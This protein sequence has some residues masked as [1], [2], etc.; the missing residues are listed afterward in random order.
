MGNDGGSISKVQNLKLSLDPEVKR[1]KI[2]TNE[3]NSV[4]RWKV[5]R[6]TNTP[7]RL[8]IVSDY[9]GYLY[10]KESILEWMLASPSKGCYSTSQIK[11]LSHIKRIHDV[12]ELANL[13]EV[14]T[15]SG[16]FLRCNFGDD[17][18]GDDMKS[19][20]VYVVPCGDV[21]PRITTELSSSND[22]SMKCPQCM[23][24]CSKENIIP[25]NPQ[26]T[27]D[28]QRLKDRYQ[29]LSRDNLYHD[30]TAKKRKKM[31]RRRGA[32]EATLSSKKTKI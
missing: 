30:G 32:N 19:T 13:D 6:V 14:K 11:Q 29:R 27:Q 7:L 24:P 21:L 3:F 4:S 9:K 2:E 12:V 28:I 8:P 26:A 1:S 5:C 20:F 22:K 15:A 31:K 10:N 16:I 17:I 23:T 18:L 25:I